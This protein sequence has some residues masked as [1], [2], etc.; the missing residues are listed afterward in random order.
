MSR[1]HV[2][3]LAARRSAS[4]DDVYESCA[5]ASVADLF[6]GM[7][8]CVFVYGQTGAGKA[9]G[10]SAP[11]HTLHA[12]QLESHTPRLSTRATHST[13]L[14]LNRTPTFWGINAFFVFMFACSCTSIP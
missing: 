13:P 1:D 6:N 14:N 9:R 5:R 4:Q 3:A 8:S 12:S 11:R 7:P 10:A 2:W